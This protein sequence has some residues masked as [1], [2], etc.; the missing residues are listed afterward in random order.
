MTIYKVVLEK[1][2]S[3]H[4]NL[5]TDLIKG[6]TLNLPAPGERFIMTGESLAPGGARRL[7]STTPVKMLEMHGK[8]MMFHTENST[9][10]LAVNDEIDGGDDAA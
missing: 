10:K 7:V 2:R 4:N 9:Y 6:E 3:K 8:E 5:R 1:I